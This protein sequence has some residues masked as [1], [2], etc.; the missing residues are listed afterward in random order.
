VVAAGAVG[1][2]IAGGV[3]AV[4][5]VVAAGAFVA[6]GVTATGGAVAAGAVVAGGVM[7]TGGAVAAGVVVA[8]GAVAAGGVSG[9]VA[10]GAVVAGGVS[11]AVAAG[12]FVPA[13]PVSGGGVCAVALFGAGFV[14]VSPAAAVEGSP[15]HAAAVSKHDRLAS[16]SHFFP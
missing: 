13:L 15:E 10:A 14:P 2:V 11:G 4:G 16:A 1:A 6:G 9:A 7:A 3:A 5:G 8:G 12:A